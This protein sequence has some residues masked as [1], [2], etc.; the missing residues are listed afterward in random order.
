MKNRVLVLTNDRR[1]GD[2]SS[3][4]KNT[5]VNMGEYPQPNKPLVF[6]DEDSKKLVQ[7]DELKTEGLYLVYDSIDQAFLRKLIEESIGKNDNTYILTHSRG[8]TR[9]SGFF[10]A[11]ARFIVRESAHENNSFSLYFR[12]F[13]ILCDGK[14]GK[15]DRIIK[16]VFRPSLDLILNFL[17]QSLDLSVLLE[18]P[19]ADVD[20]KI[21]LFNE[22]KNKIM[23]MLPRDSEA[24]QKL[25]L[26]QGRAIPQDLR[27]ALLDFALSED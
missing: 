13:E 10:N 11:Y 4:I 5:I 16:S 8:I 20:S 3:D 7:V 6:C 21:M 9:G 26:Y 27:D 24:Y 15:L 18:K 25:Q 22:L 12:L 1:L 23:E 14:R 19:N 2:F 17:H